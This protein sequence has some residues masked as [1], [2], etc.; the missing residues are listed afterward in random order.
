MNY[1]EGEIVAY[2]YFDHRSTSRKGG[3]KSKKIPHTTQAKFIKLYGPSSAYLEFSTPAGENI[4]AVP[5]SRISKL[6]K[7]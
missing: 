2:E 4:R 6:E 3:N 5:L 7:I 1:R